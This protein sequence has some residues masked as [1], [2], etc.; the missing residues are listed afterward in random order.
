MNPLNPASR[1][2]S[3][4]ALWRMGV[5]ISIVVLVTTLVAYAYLYQHLKDTALASL[6]D[7]VQQRGEAES[8][9]FLLAETQTAMMTREFLRRYHASQ[10]QDFSAEFKRIFEQGSDGLWRVRASLN[11]YRNRATVFVPQLMRPCAVKKAANPR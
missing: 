1:S 5:R 8:Q 11:D 2:L 9:Q 10:G 3:A 6:Q 4:R 7:Y